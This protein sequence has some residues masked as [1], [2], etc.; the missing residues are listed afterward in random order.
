MPEMPMR[1]YF[2]MQSDISIV[3]GNVLG[4]NGT[5]YSE[6]DWNTAKRRVRKYK[7]YSIRKPIC[8]VDII[9]VDVKFNF[10]CFQLIAIFLLQLRIYGN[11]FASGANDPKYL[12]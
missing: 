10:V 12:Y 9:L 8:N 5:I 2:H 3:Y 1:C 4:H 11:N 6:S 7:E